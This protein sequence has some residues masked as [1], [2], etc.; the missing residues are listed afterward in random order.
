VVHD[1]VDYADLG[2][3]WAQRSAPPNTAPAAW[4]TSLSNLATRS[5][6]N[7]PNDQ[8]ACGPTLAEVVT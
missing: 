4:S 2:P 5:L 6:C 1:R 7:P 8:R 3:D